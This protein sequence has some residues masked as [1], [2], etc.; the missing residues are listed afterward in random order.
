MSTVGIIDRQ[1]VTVVTSLVGNT[2][3][4]IDFIQR[5]FCLDDIGS[6]PEPP[7]SGPSP[8]GVLEDLA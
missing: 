4:G 8:T 3:F 2:G 7:A 5:R 1:P 6:L